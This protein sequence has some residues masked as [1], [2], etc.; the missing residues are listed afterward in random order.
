MNKYIAT[1]KGSEYSITFQE[2]KGLLKIVVIEINSKP[3]IQYSTSYSLEDLVKKN[4]FFKLFDSVIDLL[5]DLDIFMKNHKYAL[6][7]EHGGVKMSLYL[8]LKIVEEIVFVVP[9]IE[10]NEKTFNVE[11]V[12]CLN[13]LN[14]QIQQMNSKILFLSEIIEPLKDDPQILSRIATIKANQALKSELLILDDTEMNFLKNCIPQETNKIMKMTLL[15][16]LTKDSDQ[17]SVFHKLCDH[18]GPSLTVVKTTKGYRAGGFTSIS[19][20]SSGSY[21]NDTKAFVFSLDR[22]KMYKEPSNGS[23]AIYCNNSYGPTFGAGHDLYVANGCNSNTNSY[24]NFPYSY[25]GGLQYELTGLEKT[26]TAK[27]VEVYLITYE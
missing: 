27:D 18:K 22:K 12:E 16:K 13:N 23:N 5:P 14:K 2:E 21:K 7:L 1:D 6:S 25:T 20:D 10:S 9:Q 8:P 15:Y 11:V 19:W 26:F 3:T 17:A 4:K 24:C